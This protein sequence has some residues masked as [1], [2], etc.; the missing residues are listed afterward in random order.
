VFFSA[1]LISWWSACFTPVPDAAIDAGP[2]GGTIAVRIEDHLGNEWPAAAIPRRPWFVL[3]APVDSEDDA[4]PVMLLRGRADREI[5]EDLERAPLTIASADRVVVL[6][7]VRAGGGVRARPIRPLPAGEAFVFAVAGWASGR[8]EVPIAIELEVS[9]ELAAGAQV[10]GAWPADETA[11]V[12]IALPMAAIA[13]DGAIALDPD[14]VRIERSETPVAAAL[15]TVSCESLGFDAAVCV[16]VYPAEPLA[17]S[18]PHHLVFDHRITD[19]TGAPIGPFRSAFATGE[20]IEWSS[21]D[22]I[23][24]T[25]G[26]DEEAAEHAC[27]FSDDR[28]VSIAARAAGPMRF[29]VEAGARRDAAVAPRGEAVLALDGFVPGED[30]PLVL[31]AID[32][33]GIEQRFDLA[34]A[35][36]SELATLSIAEVRSDPRGPEPGQEY[37]EI[38]NYGTAAIDLQGFSLADRADREGDAIAER[39]VLAAGARLLIVPSGFVPD[40]ETDPAVPPGVLLGRVDGSLGSAGISNSG[41]P[42]Y[43]R[44]PEGRRVSSAPP[45]ASFAGSCLARTGSDPRTGAPD[46]F[47]LRDLCTPGVR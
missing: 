24:A 21:P 41:E 25:C 46:A 20:A 1:L 34:I 23:A 30:V 10:I 19:A 17:P 47:E 39:L 4:E 43:L 42:L 22:V 32:L 5:V 27:L 40:A 33:A 6:E 44:D 45:F 36:K 14:A 37:V 13:F 9:R 15:E 7:I 28:S 38:L 3:D 2:D 16:A 8:D 31:R 12:P 35:T 26:L 29:F 11:G 18:A